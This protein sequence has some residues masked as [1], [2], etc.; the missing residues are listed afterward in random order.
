MLMKRFTSHMLRIISPL[1]GH[2]I[3]SAGE[4]L[5]HPLETIH[6]SDMLSVMSQIVEHSP[7]VSELVV[8]GIV[9]GFSSSPLFRTPVLLGVVPKALPLMEGYLPQPMVSAIE[10]IGKY[11]IASWLGTIYRLWVG[12]RSLIRWIFFAMSITMRGTYHVLVPL[13]HGDASGLF[14]HFPLNLFTQDRK[15]GQP[16]LSWPSL[17]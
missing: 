8:Q 7:A 9:T 14:A 5:H 4:V 10:F 12:R 17:C 3:H 13:F 16:L 2:L 1:F 11:K 6:L 15:L